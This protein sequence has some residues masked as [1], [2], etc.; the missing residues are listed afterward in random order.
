M[1]TNVKNGMAFRYR[2][3][4]CWGNLK[5]IVF[6]EM[7]KR[8]PL[9]K[10]LLDESFFKG[11]I[12]IGNPNREKDSSLSSFIG[13]RLGTTDDPELLYALSFADFSK[14]GFKEFKDSTYL[15]K[16]TTRT[17]SAYETVSPKYPLVRQLLLSKFVDD[18]EWNHPTDKRR[19][20]WMLGSIT[21]T[22][23]YGGGN[24]KRGMMQSIRSAVNGVCRAD[25]EYSYLL[26]LFNELIRDSN[27]GERIHKKMIKMSPKAL[28]LG[29]KGAKWDEESKELCLYA[30]A[31]AYRKLKREGWE[32][33]G[34][35]PGKYAWKGKGGIV[36][37]E[38]M[39]MAIPFIDEEFNPPPDLAGTL[40]EDKRSAEYFRLRDKLE[41][42]LMDMHC[43]CQLT[44]RVFNSLKP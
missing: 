40:A 3:P 19:T 41:R 5:G 31:S 35:K 39:Q 43:Y 12:S 11:L 22:T 24:A 28:V 10:K 14:Q 15:R 1:K 26:F 44:E 9:H 21:S 23:H 27:F 34:S 13:V 7:F 6:T 16:R 29:S 8:E 30:R 32:R 17:S 4:T 33:R 42:H 20:E 25:S 36:Y 37:L 38:D 18:L 2:V